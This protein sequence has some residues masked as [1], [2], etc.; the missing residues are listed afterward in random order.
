VGGKAKI[1]QMMGQ[2]KS[3]TQVVGQS[4]DRVRAINWFAKKYFMEVN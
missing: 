2:M 3:I 1:E 4:A